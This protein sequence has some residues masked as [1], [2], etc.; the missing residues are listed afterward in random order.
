[1]ENN[2]QITFGRMLHLGDGFVQRQLSHRLESNIFQPH[3]MLGD[4]VGDAGDLMGMNGAARM[5]YAINRVPFPQK[6]GKQ[7]IYLKKP[8]TSRVRQGDHPVSPEDTKTVDHVEFSYGTEFWKPEE[9]YQIEMSRYQFIRPFTEFENI[10]MQ[11][12][13]DLKTFVEEQMIARLAGRMGLSAKYGWGT[14]AG[15]NEV[16]NSDNDTQIKSHPSY[17][18]LAR[19]T[20]LNEPTERLSPWT[21]D[22]DF[23]T[24]PTHNPAQITADNNQIDYDFLATVSYW[25]NM[26]SNPLYT[27]NL[28]FKTPMMNRLE[29]VAPGQG[30]P[31][32]MWNRI[33]NS[34][35]M[36][37]LY[38]NKQQVL[39]LRKE[40]SWN[41]MQRDMAQG[42]GVKSGRSSGQLGD[43]AGMRVY[44]MPYSLIY[45]ANNAAGTKVKIA[46]GLMLGMG[47]MLLVAP[48][49]PMVPTRYQ[50]AVKHFDENSAQGQRFKFFVPFQGIGDRAGLFWQTEMT[51]VPVRWSGLEADGELKDKAIS[52]IIAIDS[53]VQ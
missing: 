26:H 22:L 23:D 46:R 42:Q 43:I 17:E 33:P 48:Q 50:P 11:L 49:Y 16:Q 19:G 9:G 40:D 34:N 4:L 1:M 20:G 15:G 14:F 8:Q 28:A 51:F 18:S 5:E 52:N 29:E 6:Q 35:V 31:A 13:Q 36:G 27:R 12:K 3:S 37:V 2:E 41:E 44:E 25:I 32:A 10:E 45:E 53:V 7:T 24:H 30:G 39:A 47:A 38:L 21:P